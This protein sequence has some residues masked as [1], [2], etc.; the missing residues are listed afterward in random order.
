MQPYVSYEFLSYDRT[1]WSTKR[2][3][4]RQASSR[5]D[6]VLG[7]PRASLGACAIHFFF[8][9]GPFKEPRR[10]L[11]YLL[12]AGCL[13]SPGGTVAPLR[14]QAAPP[15]AIF[16]STTGWALPAPS[17]LVPLHPDAIFSSQR[18]ND[19]HCAWSPL[20]TPSWPRQRRHELRRPQPR[21]PLWSLPLVLD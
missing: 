16:S 3:R 4:D 14:S 19:P 20:A 13:L 17:V 21:Q 15:P 2:E 5:S 7:L 9:E 6:F 10:V 11:F 8:S 1:L 18:E 12:L